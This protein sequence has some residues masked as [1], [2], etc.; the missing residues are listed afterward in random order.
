MKIFWYKEAKSSESRSYR[1][2]NE[3]NTISFLFYLLSE[4]VNFIT[5]ME[6]L[7]AVKSIFSLEGPIMV[8]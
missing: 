4:I 7:T 8:E 5:E 6:M 2:E 1:D 3:R